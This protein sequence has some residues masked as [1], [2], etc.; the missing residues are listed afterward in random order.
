MSLSPETQR[1]LSKIDSP[2]IQQSAISAA[3][4]VVTANS[5][6][7]G[8]SA[9][10]TFV[11]LIRFGTAYKDYEAKA[12][13]RGRNLMEARSVE[14]DSLKDII[15]KSGINYFGGMFQQGDECTPLI[16][17]EIVLGRLERAGFE[18]RPLDALTD[19]QLD[20]FYTKTLES[21]LVTNS[22]FEPENV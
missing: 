19:D 4:L 10:Q 12:M 8:R 13:P 1:I 22:T 16:E 21:G 2:D 20:L 18:V 6:E 3:M 7:A 15:N 17:R 5:P 9:Q 14:G 11:A